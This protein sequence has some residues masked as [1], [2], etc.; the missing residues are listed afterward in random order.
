VCIFSDTRIRGHN[1][2]Y[3][4]NPATMMCCRFGERV[5]CKVL[6]A[7]PGG[8]TLEPCGRGAINSF[9]ASTVRHHL[10]S[11]C[12]QMQAGLKSRI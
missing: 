3:I 8:M 4:P 10:F 6:E 5:R 1:T 7:C 2:L 11:A 9:R 12:F